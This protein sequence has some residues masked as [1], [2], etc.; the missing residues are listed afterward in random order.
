MNQRIIIN[1]FNHQLSIEEYCS[2]LKETNS[3]VATAI[4]FYISSLPFDEEVY[5]SSDLWENLFGFKKTMSES[6][7]KILIKKNYLFQK[8]KLKFEAS[9]KRE[10]KEKDKDKYSVYCH[11]FPNKKKYIGI[12][13]DIQK[14]WKNGKGYENNFD[15]WNDIVKYGW[16]NIQHKIIKDNLTKDEALKL[17][18][19]L[20]VEEDSIKNGY[21]RI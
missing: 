5:C 4:L 13:N 11:I 1:K 2:I 18:R 12:S 21:N 3:S 7:I 14:R 20:I 17:E 9:L 10:E 16:S 6:G 8:D 19:Q 15:M